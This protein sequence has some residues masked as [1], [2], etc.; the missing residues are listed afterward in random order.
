MW[1]WFLAHHRGVGVLASLGGASLVVVGSV[2]L[3][4][5][6]GR[7]RALLAR[8]KALDEQRA[9]RIDELSSKLSAVWAGYA[10]SDFRS[11]YDYREEPALDLLADEWHRLRTER[12]EAGWGVFVANPGYGRSEADQLLTESAWKVQSRQGAV[13]LAGGFL[14]VLGV[15]LTSV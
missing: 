6:I 14:T 2:W 9:K 15:V 11:R 4:W 5:S 1:S 3:T 13:S 12:M 8:D 10:S 7:D